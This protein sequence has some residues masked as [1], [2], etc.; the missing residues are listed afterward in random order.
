MKTISGDLISLAVHGNFDVIVHGCNCYNN[1]GAGIAL[2]V[3]HN[4]PEAY[5]ADQNTRRGDLSKL[6]NI[7]YAEHT[8]RFDGKSKLIIVNGY[9][10]FAYGGGVRRADYKA[11][12]SVFANVKKQFHG[13]RIAYPRIGAGLA[14]GNWD[15]ISKI[16][17]IEL[18]GE[19]HTFVEYEQCNAE[20]KYFNFTE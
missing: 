15:L 20:G 2:S 9:T 19:D 6:G 14:R 16:I 4:F 8:L 1:M 5:H 18:E 13:A 11:I 17:N 12:H 3:K 7:S 10:Q